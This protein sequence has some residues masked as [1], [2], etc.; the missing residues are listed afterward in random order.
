LDPLDARRGT[1]AAAGG[2]YTTADGGASWH[3]ARSCPGRVFS[4]L[5]P[6]A[7][8]RLAGGARGL[9]VSR[10]GGRS[11]R[12]Q[13]PLTGATVEWSTTHPLPVYALW[14]V[15]PGELLAGSGVGLL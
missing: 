12:P 9:C 5:A 7:S 13:A 15:A 3:A 6:S 11:W 8:L 14:Q 1:A 4:L 2:L 10:D